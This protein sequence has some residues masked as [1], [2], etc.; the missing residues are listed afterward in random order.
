MAAREA[1]DREEEEAFV[2]TNL[3]ACGVVLVVE[4]TAGAPRSCAPAAIFLPRRKSCS[5]RI[6]WNGTMTNSAPS[7]TDAE[8]LAN[9][10]TSDL[11][12]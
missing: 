5:A 2:Q 7:S 1:D 9:G 11:V 6:G 12:Q 10:S 3:A 4:I 8:R